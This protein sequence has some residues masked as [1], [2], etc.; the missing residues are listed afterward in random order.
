ME[1]E[2][3]E[4]KLDKFIPPNEIILDNY[5]LTY[6]QKL[7]NSNY[8][9]RCKNRR[10]CSYTITISEEVLKSIAH[11]EQNIK[12]NYK[13]SSKQKTHTCS[14]DNNEEN[15]GNISII[16]SSTTTLRE[17][18]K[19]LMVLN[20]EKKFSWHKTNLQNNK[21]L[22]SNNQIKYLLQQLREVKFPN[23]INFLKDI[24][25]IKI[26]LGNTHNLVNI[27]FCHRYVNY[28]NYK[29]NKVEKYIIFT[30]VF[31]LNLL[32]KA[33]QIFI[34][35]TFKSSPKNFYQILNIAGYYKELN[36]IIPLVFIPMSSKSEII[37]NKIFTDLID[38]MENFNI[39]RNNICKL[40]MSDFECALRKS[41][42]KFFP[43]SKLN[44][45]YFHFVKILW[46]KAKQLSLCNKS[47]IKNTKLLIFLFKTLPFIESDNKSIF[48]DQI[49]NFF[50]KLDNQYDK[51]ITYFEKNWYNSK[52]IYLDAINQ[53]E[54]LYRTNNYIE[55]FHKQL[56]EEI[57]GFHPKISYLVDKLKLFT[58]KGYQF[59]IESIIN[60][61]EEKYEKYSIINDILNFIAK[62][63]KKYHISLNANMIIQGEGETISDIDNVCKKVL[64]LLFDVEDGKTGL[65]EK[66]DILNESKGNNIL[67]LEKESSDLEENELNKENQIIICEEQ[68]G[69]L[70]SIFIDEFNEN[71]N[72][73]KKKRN[74]LSLEN[75]LTKFYDNLKISNKSNNQLIDN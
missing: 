26:D 21:I 17:L 31:Q 64:E 53:K 32:T 69:D 20:L 57:E 24:S 34:D 2:K 73:K 56:N 35:S 61:K 50:S 43:Y 38:I 39:K 63:N 48:Y 25:L 37:Y 3:Y 42:K 49:K 7:S 60:K 45:C 54:Y 22:L 41:M 5:K 40:I 66:E 46:E 65:N 12:I 13:I 58:I 14:E 28:I 33:E 11:K 75:D 19:K 4:D 1:S 9:Y 6:K 44:G 16:K 71:E 68:D 47:K 23:D 74:H 51:F 29:K 55:N 62:F 67:D 30:S 10:I 70:D 18:A 8:S 36:S 72:Y 27:P 52:Y 59:Y 15:S